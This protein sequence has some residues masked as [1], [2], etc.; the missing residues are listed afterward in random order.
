MV[1]KINAHLSGLIL[2][3]CIK[4]VKTKCL[5]SFR[6]INILLMPLKGALLAFLDNFHKPFFI[7]IFDVN[8]F[9]SLQSEVLG[10]QC[11]ICSNTHEE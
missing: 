7:F 1:S 3:G 9:C 2:L 11:C 6:V 8:R 4:G 10:V 5:C